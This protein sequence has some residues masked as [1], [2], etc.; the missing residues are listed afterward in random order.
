M[1]LMCALCI[2]N[3]KKHCKFDL[4]VF[5]WIKNIQKVEISE[6]FREFELKNVVH[7]W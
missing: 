6:D 7:E 1:Q 2:E 3:D 5:L 4:D